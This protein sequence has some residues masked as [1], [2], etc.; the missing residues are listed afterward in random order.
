MVLVV[1]DYGESM[2]KCGF[3]CENAVAPGCF[4]RLLAVF[5]PFLQIGCQPVRYGRRHGL[6]QW[7]EKW[8]VF[9]QKILRATK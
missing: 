4:S 3:A 6:C 8:A 7:V 5:C 9:G 2:T 1:N